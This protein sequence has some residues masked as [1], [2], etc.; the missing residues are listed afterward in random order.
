M[1]EEIKSAI[2]RVLPFAIA[3]L[4]ILILLKKNRITRDS[5][6][7]RK[8]VSMSRFFAWW[9]GFLLLAMGIEYMLFKSGHLEVS[10]WEHAFAPSVIRIFG[11]VVL[12]PVAEELL[13]RGIITNRLQNFNLNLHVVVIL[14]ALLFVL[15]H[16]FAYE[17][18]VSSNIGIIQSFFDACLFAYA[19]IN[20]KSIYTCIAM[21]ATGNAIAVIEQFIF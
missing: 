12:A 1:T 3:L 8:P 9:G 19:R 18:T 7:I 10:H 4:L 15:M 2:F 21:H 17:N 5:L 14:Q 11:I 13:F 16:S 20:T 6:Y